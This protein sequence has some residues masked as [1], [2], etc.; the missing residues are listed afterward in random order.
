MSKSLQ[1]FREWAITQGQVANP[2]VNTYRGQCVSLIQQYLYQVFNI[3]FAPRGHA[4]DFVPPTFARIATSELR[5]GDIVRYGAAYG[6]GYGHIG[7]IDD[8]GKYLDQ[9]GVVAMRIGRRDK[10]FGYINAVFR[11]TKSF[12]VKNPASE[13]KPAPTPKPTNSFLGARGYLTKGD[14]GENIRQVNLFFR[15]T[16]PAYAP[17]AVLGPLFGPITERTVREFQRR[18]KADG[19]YNDVVDGQVGPKTYQ[20]MKSYGFKG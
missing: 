18:A 8:E 7:L 4:K 2:T 10:P 14:V 17:Q 15:N 9:N 5:P 16:F 11:P 1:T 3:P 13:P 12:V 6:G 19:R 20:A